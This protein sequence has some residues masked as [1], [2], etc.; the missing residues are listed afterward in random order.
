MH[1]QRRP[2][3][4]T[5]SVSGPENV[6]STPSY[7]NALRP[8]PSSQRTPLVKRGY[9][10][11][12][13]PSARD[14]EARASACASDKGLHV[15]DHIAPNEGDFVRVSAARRRSRVHK[16]VWNG[17]S[18]VMLSGLVRCITYL[19][20]RKLDG[21][22]FATSRQRRVFRTLGELRDTLFLDRWVGLPME[23]PSINY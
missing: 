7:L 14:D 20:R 22:C 12:G 13:F 4:A 1:L 3:P 10:Q 2:Q 11:L 15:A 9:D 6:P 23:F 5:V 19:G 17:W 16:H 18:S 21:V 8:G